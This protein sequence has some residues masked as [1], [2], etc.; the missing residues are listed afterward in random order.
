MAEI[1]WRIA[2]KTC[3][4]KLSRD[5]VTLVILVAHVTLDG[6]TLRKLNHTPQQVLSLVAQPRKVT[7]ETESKGNTQ[8][9]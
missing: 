1:S 3:N 4:T 9:K 2:P 8:L 5:C 7:H 6:N